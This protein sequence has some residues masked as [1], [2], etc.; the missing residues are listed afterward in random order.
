MGFADHYIPHDQLDA[1]TQAIIDDGVPAALAAHAVEPPPSELAAQRVWIDKCYSGDT[2]ED[3]IAA[4]RG[5]DSGPAQDAANLISSRSPIAL[6]VTLQAV[7]RA[8]KLKTLE[9]VLKQ[10]YRV[11]SASL[12]S[13]DLV[14]GIR[15]QLV[16]KDRN[17]QWSPATLSAVSAAD[18][19]AYFAPVDDD[20]SF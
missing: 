1:F 3:I 5:H 18:V 7:R 12:R 10:D 11:S 17:P 19:D 15:A 9:D 8:G 4:L 20:L 2:V 13:H 16:D 14:E 6:S